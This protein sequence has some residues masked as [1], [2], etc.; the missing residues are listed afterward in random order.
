MN[1]KARWYKL[2]TFK[3]GHGKPNN[4]KAN[5]SYKNMKKKPYFL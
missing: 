2:L 3:H 1:I 4:N 5:K